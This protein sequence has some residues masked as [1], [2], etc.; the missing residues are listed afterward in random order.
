MTAL[1]DGTAI[2]AHFPV[3][4]RTIDGQRLVYLD[5]ANTSQKPQCVIDAM[6]DFLAHGYGP[7]NRSAYRLAA[8]ATDAYEGARTKLQRFIN[9]RRPHEIIFTKNAT[10]SINLIVHSWARANMQAG[11]AVVLTHMEHHANI[12]PWQMLAAE[13][14]IEIRWVPLTADGRLD[15]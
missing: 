10:E 1:L 14:G 15:L 7:I 13:R 4:Q 9:A 11:D 8:E 2:A 3:L 6:A 5:S 12:V